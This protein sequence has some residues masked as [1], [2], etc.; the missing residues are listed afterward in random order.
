MWNVHNA[1]ESRN[2]RNTDDSLGSGTKLLLPSLSL[3]FP[4]EER[5]TQF[6]YADCSSIVSS[7]LTDPTNARAHPAIHKLHR[8]RPGP[9][10]NSLRLSPNLNSLL[11]FKI[12][13]NPSPSL[14][15]MTSFTSPVLFSIWC[16]YSD[17]WDCH[18]LPARA[19][20]PAL[21]S[22]PT[23]ALNRKVLSLTK[24]KDKIYKTK[25][26]NIKKILP[27]LYKRRKLWKRSLLVALDANFT[28]TYISS[29]SSCW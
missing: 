23:H 13:K 18:I 27:Q 9:K 2:T 24:P 20:T 16:F 11:L 1:E 3:G 26:D 7:Q 8:P 19:W 29:S 17:I 22:A 12:T 4:H 15:G 10:N 5:E 21:M 28:Y 25:N 14:P 6:F